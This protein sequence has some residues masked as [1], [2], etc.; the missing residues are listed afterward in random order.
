M[1]TQSAHRA[2][3]NAFGA[4]YDSWLDRVQNYPHTTSL[5]RIHGACDMVQPYSDDDAF[6]YWISE[7]FLECVKH[8]RNSGVRYVD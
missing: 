3:K 8:T 5:D 7:A 4:S 1:I 6:L 2:A